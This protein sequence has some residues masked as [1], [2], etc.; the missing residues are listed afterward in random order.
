M[1]ALYLFQIGLHLVAIILW[2]CLLNQYTQR[3]KLT[4][5]VYF[6]LFMSVFF[7]IAQL[8]FVAGWYVNALS[9]FGEWAWLFFDYFNAMFSISIFLFLHKYIEQQNLIKKKCKDV[10]K[11]C[12]YGF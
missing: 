7:I 8:Y 5:L 10:G 11:D 3:P 4:I 2:L 12:Y 9:N 1:I 6:G